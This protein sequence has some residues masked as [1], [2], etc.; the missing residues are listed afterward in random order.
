VAANDDD[1][2]AA[3][4]ALANSS[5][6]QLGF[7]VLTTRQLGDSLQIA[8]GHSPN[9]IYEFVVRER[10]EDPF[11]SIAYTLALN[12][13]SRPATRAE[14]LGRALAQSSGR[15]FDSNPFLL[16]YDFGG[17][18]FMA[19][20]AAK[21]FGAF[22][23]KVATESL[24]I[25]DT[26]SFSLSPSFQ[27]RTVSMYATVREPDVWHSPIDTSALSLSQMIT[28]LKQIRDET[29]AAAP[30][31]PA[32][33]RA[34]EN[35][36]RPG[37]GAKGLDAPEL[38]G[39]AHA[40]E[41]AFGETTKEQV[42]AAFEATQDEDWKSRPGVEPY[43]LLRIGTEEKP[44]KAVF[45]RIAGDTNFNTQ[46]A[47]RVLRRLG[48]DVLNSRETS[49]ASPSRRYWLWAPG[50][51]ADQ[52]EESRA[53]GEMGI[54]WT[55]LGDLARFQSIDEVAG[56]IK[57]LYG[58]EGE[59]VNDARTT[60]DFSHEVSK[61]DIV[62]AKTGQTTL[63]GAGIVT[64]PYFREESRSSGF[65]NFHSVEWVRIGQWEVPTGEKFPIKTLT[66]ITKW[67]E[68]IEK[69]TSLVGGIPTVGR[70]AT[71]ITKPS[72]RAAK[73]ELQDLSNESGFDL[74]VLQ[75]WLRQLQRKKHLVFQGPPGTGKTFLAKGLA[76]TLV[77]ETEGIFEVV[78]FHPSYAYEDFIQGI[79]PRANG[80]SLQYSLEPG[81]FLAFCERASKV[82]TGPAVLIV[83]EMN[84][85]NL[86]RVFGELMYL[87]EYREEKV[88]L[89]AGGSFAV[90]S[91][92]L[93]IGTMN[94]ADRS[95]ALVDHALRRRFTFVHLGPEYE[96]LRRHLNKHGLPASSLVTALK[97]V[98]EAIRD[99]NYLVGVSFFMKDGATLKSTL[100]DVWHGEIEPY[101]EEYFFDQPE[102]VGPLRLEA[103][104]KE[105]L[106]EWA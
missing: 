87:L 74:E 96:V 89:S 13:A 35:R 47:A 104:Y 37:L 50:K 41:E 15:L 44:L 79:R 91:N 105:Q 18:Q 68:F 25:S 106:K 90:P 21:L 3:F 102:R 28:G 92:V 85:A 10:N 60:W 45:R 12:A 33:I 36:I 75:R 43:W 49:A 9:P 1:I 53:N 23:K 24:N 32:I 83:D 42:I 27:H 55:D 71:K 99:P 76:K 20:S 56:A 93:V 51:N 61:G 86:S 103:L 14:A 81:R 80:G 46:T 31:I 88:P 6:G 29:R 19:V 101:L 2:R 73:Y 58:K 97:L 63:L 69:L 52:W 98:N 7:R 40:D 95:I 64:G 34:I 84:R 65:K 39:S 48:F 8:L 22:A 82:E 38:V 11:L 70:G 77:S 62:F 30:D 26:A 59:P 5:G 54:G 67:P 66:E 94:T 100:P 16:V 78:Q 57:Q 4:D 17:R 72:L